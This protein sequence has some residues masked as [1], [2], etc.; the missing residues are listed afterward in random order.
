MRSQDV[1]QEQESRCRGL[2]LLTLVRP[3]PPVIIVTCWVA[4]L[5]TG[6][7][8]TRGKRKIV[9]DEDDLDEDEVSLNTSVWLAG[10][11]LSEQEEDS[12][13]ESEEEARPVRSKKRVSNGAVKSKAPPALR[14]P[15]KTNGAAANL[16]SDGPEPDLA[17]GL[18]T[19]NPLFSELL[20]LD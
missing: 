12:A 17:E 2:R 19:D 18:K 16:H 11:M 14:K 6:P 15:K 5:M 8:A 4:K 20:S 10:C 1:V 13:E 3:P 9:D 7:A